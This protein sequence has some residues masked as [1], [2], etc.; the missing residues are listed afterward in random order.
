M[1]QEMNDKSLDELR[2]ACNDQLEEFRRKKRPQQKG[3]FYDSQACTE[4]VRRALSKD[5]PALALL[6]EMM[7]T[8]LA[9]YC[10]RKH[11]S[12]TIEDR[13]D[14]VQETCLN[15][16]K[17]WTEKPVT[18]TFASFALF[19]NY[20]YLTAD[21]LQK[22]KYRG[23][24]RRGLLATVSIDAEREKDARPQIERLYLGVQDT[25]DK[26]SYLLALLERCLQKGLEYDLM[27]LRFMLGEDPEDIIALCQT[28][29]PGIDRKGVY[30]A[31]D[32]AKRKFLPC[33]REFGENLV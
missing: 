8:H 28:K 15:L 33:A 27:Y 4:I 1:A 31:L 24:A 9:S 25:P 6:M 2:S 29:Y 26:R 17:R 12:L 19:L 23:E 3:V 18:N 14:L 10:A 11:P 30:R 13:E 20:I 32:T 5:K 16:Y 7:Q 21:N 22:N